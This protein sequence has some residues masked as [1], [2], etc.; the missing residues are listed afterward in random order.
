MLIYFFPP[1]VTDDLIRVY[2]HP[3]LLYNPYRRRSIFE[4]Y[5]GGSTHAGGEVIV[6][7]ATIVR[8]INSIKAVSKFQKNSEIFYAVV[9]HAEIETAFKVDRMQLIMPRSPLTT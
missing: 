1:S 3:N 7:N 6:C 8:Y 4:R 5:A 2:S 9:G